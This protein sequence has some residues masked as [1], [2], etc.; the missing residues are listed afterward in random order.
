MVDLT[1]MKNFTV[2]SGSRNPRGSRMNFKSAVARAEKPRHTHYAD[3][4][5]RI[6]KN[7]FKFSPISDLDN[8]SEGSL[9][10][11]M[12][13]VED[14]EKKTPLMMQMAEAIKRQTQHLAKQA[15]IKSEV[16]QVSLQH[17]KQYAK[18]RNSQDTAVQGFLTDMAIVNQKADNDA[19]FKAL[20]GSENYKEEQISFQ[21]RVRG[22]YLNQ[23]QKAIDRDRN[24]RFKTYARQLAQQE[25]VA[26]NWMEGKATTRQARDAQAEASRLRAAGPEGS[27]KVGPFAGLLRVFS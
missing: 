10:S 7:Y 27:V 18:A 26:V 21:D 22:L 9:A 11:R 19:A 12:A 25:R 24:E 15:E 6:I 23:E 17:A 20:E 2:P 14:L 16:V 5:D 3:R 4:G 1:R 8:V 13:V